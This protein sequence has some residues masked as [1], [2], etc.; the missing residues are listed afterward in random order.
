MKPFEYV[1]ATDTTEAIALLGNGGG[2]EIRL[3][4][5]GTDL[6]TL[7]KA[8][9]AAPAQLIDIK[10]LGLPHEI[11][12]TPQGVTIGA[13][14]RLSEIE[15]SPL[16]Q[17]RYPVL[18]QAAAGAATPQLRNMATL[19]GNL[20]QRPRCWYFRSPLF[21]CWLKGGDECQARNGENQLHAIFGSEPCCAVHPSDFAPAL[22]TLDAEVRLQGREGERRL[23]LEEFYTLPQLHPKGHRGNARLRARRQETLI[24]PDELLVSVHIPQ[25]VGESRSI[26]LKAMDRKV[27]AFALVSVAMVLHLEQNK[28]ADARIVLG[29]VAPIPWRVTAAEQALVGNEP[30]EACF[31][32]AAQEACAGARALEHNAY[33]IPLVQ[34]L[35]QRALRTLTG[36]IP[37][38]GVVHHL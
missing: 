6:L 11:V 7:M 28:I 29:G 14:T 12:E 3:L 26:Y 27:W 33:K 8:D 35:I 30:G 4:A 38:D 37:P 18:A 13:L 5:G 22:L 34:S 2:E 9:V 16:I 1:R 32:H 24:A 23:S 36:Q 21:H 19:G 20:L 10:R 15:S 17:T 25:K 31:L